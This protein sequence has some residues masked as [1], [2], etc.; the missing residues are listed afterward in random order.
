MLINYTL[1]F[2]D[3]NVNG[4]NLASEKPP[5]SR[6]CLPYPPHVDA[7]VFLAENQLLTAESSAEQSCQAVIELTVLSPE[8]AQEYPTIYPNPSTIEPF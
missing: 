8:A 5:H 2:N 1:F 7:G 4:I 3:N 6:G